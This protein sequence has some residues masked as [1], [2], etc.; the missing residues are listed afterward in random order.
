MS[1]RRLAWLLAS[2]RVLLTLLLTPF[3]VVR[4]PIPVWV[5]VWVL[6]VAQSVQHLD[7]LQG[8]AKISPC[9]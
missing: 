9:L 7:V 5:P 1:K 4:L 2:L 6:L 3:S 8:D